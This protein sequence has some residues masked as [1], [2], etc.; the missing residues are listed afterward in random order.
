MTY[1]SLQV[2]LHGH[3]TQRCAC[4]RDP[5]EIIRHG[6]DGTTPRDG[7]IYVGSARLTS[8]VQIC[9]SNTGSPSRTENQYIIRPR[10]PLGPQWSREVKPID[11][12]IN[13]F[14]DK[15]RDPTPIFS[16]VIGHK[17]TNKSSADVNLHC[18][19]NFG[20]YAV[21]TESPNFVNLGLASVYTS[22]ELRSVFIPLECRKMSPTGS[23]PAIVLVK[24]QRIE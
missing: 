17:F 6:T 7:K 16:K 2:D 14:P 3:G 20:S 9:G 24:L 15:L 4:F 1:D 10:G 12:Y 19:M 13:G 5:A 11:T 23:L 8:P 18:Q 22:N 21:F